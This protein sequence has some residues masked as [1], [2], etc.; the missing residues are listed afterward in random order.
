MRMKFL[1]LIRMSVS[2]LWRRKLRTILTILG[3]VIGTASIVVMVS[4]GIGLNQSTMDQIEKNGGLTTIQVSPNESGYGGGMVVAATSSADSGSSEKKEPVRINDAAIETLK[5][6]PNVE[7]V[8][9]VLS[10]YVMAKQGVYEGNLT[11]KGM[12]LEALERMDIPIK[13]GTLPESDTELQL[14]Y[15]NTVITDFYNAKKQE[16]FWETG[17]LPDVDL[18]NKPLFIIFDTDAYWNSKYGGTNEDGTQIQPPKKYIIPTSGLA[19]GGPEDYNGEYSYTVYANVDALKAQLKKVFKNKAIPGQPT[20]STGKPYKEIF[21]NQAM[22]KVDKMENV[23]E[24]QDLISGMGY[25]VYSNIEWMKQMQEQ[26]NQVQ[27]VLGGIGAVSLFVAAIGI[28]NTMMMSIY[29]RT[30]EIG[31]LK[32]IGCGLRTI[33]NMFLLEA[34]FIGFIGGA[35]GLILSYGISA[36]IN[37]LTSGG[38]EGMAVAGTASTSVIP[39]WLALAALL[40]AILIGMVAGFFPALRAM[41]LSPL[42]AIRNE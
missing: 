23:Q 10:M 24:V 25:S 41:R 28:A 7:Y 8:S 4:I 38:A 22:V 9:P 17:E 39:V 16:Y 14:F 1:D 15:G 13:E 36:G 33:R 6:L 2:S 12:S 35:I 5:A 32:V 11:I 34:A 31:I 18:M 19:D 20:R 30:K 21:Y 27:A 42:A 37:F 3:V 26:A 40:F 29:E